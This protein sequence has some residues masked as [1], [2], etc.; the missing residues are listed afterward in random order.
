[1]A[2]TRG[3]VRRILK[4]VGRLALV[5]VLALAGLWVA[6]FVP[7]AYYRRQATKPS[8][9]FIVEDAPVIALIHARVIDGTGSPAM[10]DQTIVISAGENRCV[11]CL[12][13]GGSS[14]TGTSH[15]RVWQDDHPRS[16]DD[17][18]ASLHHV[19]LDNRGDPP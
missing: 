4:W 8:S 5:L 12:L 2:T 17:A 18:R 7:R 11:R 15:Q 9:A 1:M 16:R 14:S 10:D 13:C 19:V 3:I 6:I